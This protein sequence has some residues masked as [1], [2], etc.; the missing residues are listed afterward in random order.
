MSQRTSVLNEL[1]NWMVALPPKYDT[2][3]PKCSL[4]HVIPRNKYDARLPRCS[5]RQVLPSIERPGFDRVKAFEPKAN[6]LKP[7]SNKFGH[8]CTCLFELGCADKVCIS[9]QEVKM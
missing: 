9:T 5:F 2:N 4:R 6:T 7:L 3:L 1:Q 8:S